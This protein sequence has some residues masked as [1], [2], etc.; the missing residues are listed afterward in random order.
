MYLFASHLPEDA[1][2]RGAN[3]G[4]DFLFFTF[5]PVEDSIE[6]DIKKSEWVVGG[7]RRYFYVLR[8]AAEEKNRK[9]TRN[10]GEPAQV[11]SC[12]REF[13]FIFF[14]L[15]P[16]GARYKYTDIYTGSDAKGEVGEA[17]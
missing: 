7:G 15:P 13:F 9:T 2:V 16:R 12:N 4:E 8:R 5:L 11:E 17:S 6:D 1:F 3:A 14:M 10:S